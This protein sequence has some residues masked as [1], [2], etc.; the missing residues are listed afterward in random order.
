[1]SRVLCV[2]DNAGEH[3]QPGMDT[4][5]NQATRHLAQSRLLLFL[6]DPTQDQRFRDR[7]QGKDTSLPAVTYSSRQELVLL[8]VAARV[9]RL[10]NLPQS[11]RHPHPLLVLVTKYD[12]WSG[13]LGGKVITEDP[14]KTTCQEL[15]GL[16]T[17]RIA[18]ISG[19]LRRLLMETCPELISAAEGFADPVVYLPVSALGRKPILD[20][21]TRRW[22]IRPRGMRPIWSAVPLLF[23]LHR[24]LQG[25]ISSLK[26]AAPGPRLEPRR[27]ETIRR[28]AP[29]TEGG[30]AVSHELYYTSAPQGLKPGSHGFCTV[31]MTRGLPA[32]LVERLEAM[33]AY[34]PAYPPQDSRA[35]LNPVVRAHYRLTAGGRTVDVLS[36]VSSAGLDYTQRHNKFAHHVVLEADEL[37]AGGPAWLLQQPSFMATEWD[38]ELRVLSAGRRPPHG[39]APAGTCKHWERVTGDAGWAAVLAGAFLEDPARPAYLLYA[40]GFDPL[41]LLAEA[42]GLVP[43][44]RRWE[45]TFS[46]YYT[47]LPQGVRCAWRCVLHDSP[48]AAEADRLPGCWC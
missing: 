3:F 30:E 24:S 31:T 29:Q 40:P 34:R 44:E 10:T 6:F 18:D 32:A 5:H 27:A 33:S 36:R 8:E 22:T 4:T 25:V 7:L 12:I 43:A 28:L 42:A 35:P 2:Y 11:A 48:E 9:R 46:T 17:D 16:D 38:G 26:P 15:A 20:P 45:V 13:L 37:S 1:M 39:E 14:W 19:Q 23:G 47:G 41:P 21:A